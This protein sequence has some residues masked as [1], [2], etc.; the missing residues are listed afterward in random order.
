VDDFVA[1]P[2][3]RAEMLENQPSLVMIAVPELRALL[4]T[5]EVF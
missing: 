4:R 5:A 2:V 1:K 3:L